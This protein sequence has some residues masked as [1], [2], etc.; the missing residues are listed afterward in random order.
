MQDNTINKI[1]SLVKNADRFEHMQFRLLLEELLKKGGR[2]AE[3]VAGQLAVSDDVDSLTRINIIRCMGYITSNTFLI[4]L[5]KILE[6]GENLNLRKAAIISISKYNDKR[7]L[8]M[9]NMA[10]KRM[11][12]P[13][14]QDSISA[15]ISRIKTANPI[16]GLMPK[17]LNAVDD[18]KT[19]R[20]TLDVLKKVLSPQDAH[21]FIYHLNSEIPF[22]GDGAFE[23]LCWRGDESVKF[24]L[25]DYF[26]KKLKEVPCIEEDECYAL[27]HLL[28]QLEKFISRNPDTMNYV[29]KEIKELYKRAKD[30]EIKDLVID[31]FS[32]SHKREVLAFLED[33]YRQDESR[34]ELVIEKL[35]GNEN[36][37]YILL[38]KYKN[39][40]SADKEKLT[41]A[42]STTQGGSDY[43]IEI[44]DTLSPGYQKLVLDNIDIS[45]YRFF[46]KLMEQFLLSSDFGRKRF[47]LEKMKNNRDFTFHSI[48]FDPQHQAD[49]LRMQQD[50]TSAIAQLFPIK[51]F[52]FFF[53]RVINV[54]SAR[55]LLRRYFDPDANP[56]LRAEALVPSMPAE[57][58][59]T[60]ID[61]LAKFNNKELNLNFL[62]AFYYIKTQDYSTLAAWQTMLSDFR[63]L[64]GTRISPEEKGMLNKVEA[65]FLNVNG[66]IKKIQAGDTNINHFLEKEFPDYDILE[67]I[68]K[69]HPMAFF[70][71]RHAVIGRIKKTFK[72][73][74]EIDAF[75]SIKFFLKRPR[76][77]VYFKEEIEKSTKSGNYLLKED[78]D[79]L[80]ETM[81][82]SLR[83]VLVFAE[84]YLYSYFKDQ[85]HEIM[86]EAEIS[87]V[88][89]VEPGDFLLTDSESMETL[90]SE[91]RVNTK[92]LYVLLKETSE[93]AAIKDFKPKVFPSPLSLYKVMKAVIPALYVEDTPADA[94]SEDGK[95]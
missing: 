15:E 82:K 68:L 1:K 31:I 67:Y 20:T 50:F 69:K 80:V 4:P 21:K 52:K 76:L 48:V 41:L 7:A 45:N 12:N 9:L 32:T 29:L 62:T 46:I 56:F 8:N 43:L 44:F 24:S 61:K 22:V 75:D 89:D 92:R 13:I 25:F 72:M 11:E 37:A 60:F 93:F 54:D 63:G 39:D 17:F 81:P 85:L 90:V 57:N 59:S 86:P 70:T 28:S 83:F 51:T 53:S 5:R 33:V 74:K 40:E 47:A 2:D 79:K 84:N 71:R 78:A 94:A 23:V 49:F 10:L 30:P 88:P 42:L 66:D 14:L 95:D 77:S 58:L 27:S 16:L 73:L 36:G 91:N 38:Y 18:P 19:F 65:N 34:R 26:K 64:R 6:S 55:V 87:E 35:S 3:S